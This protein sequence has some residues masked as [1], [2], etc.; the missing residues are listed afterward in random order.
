MVDLGVSDLTNMDFSKDIQISNTDIVAFMCSMQMSVENIGKDIKRS[1]L[2]LG[3]EICDCKDELKGEIKQLH[4]KID[5]K[6]TKVKQGT[7]SVRL[8]MEKFNVGN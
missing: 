2:E 8:D 3:K 6:I 4:R 1:D 5:E 7:D